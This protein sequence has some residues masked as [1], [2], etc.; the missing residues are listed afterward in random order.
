MTLPPW[1]QEGGLVPTL[2][3]LADPTLP[4]RLS[5]WYA[6]TPRPWDKIRFSYIA[7]EE[8]RYLEGKTLGEVVGAGDQGKFICEVL[9]ACRLAAGCVMPHLNRDEADVRALMN[10]PAM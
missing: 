4:A 7:A 9:T 8:Y 6:A 1:V 3:R 5:E 10:H 2:E